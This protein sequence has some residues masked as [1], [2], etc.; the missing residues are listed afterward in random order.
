MSLWHSLTCEGSNNSD[1]PGQENVG[2]D[3]CQLSV[4]PSQAKGEP[5]LLTILTWLPLRPRQTTRPP[6]MIKSRL[7][8]CLTDE[9]TIPTHLMQRIE[10]ASP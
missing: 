3:D 2:G 5:M 1:L 4:I 10:E 8:F 7:S 9:K 6:L